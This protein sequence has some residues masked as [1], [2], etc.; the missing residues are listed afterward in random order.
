MW[1]K[2]EHCWRQLAGWLVPG[3]HVINS[4]C[5]LTDLN[6]LR[7]W[8]D[9]ALYFLIGLLSQCPYKWIRKQTKQKDVIARMFYSL[10]TRVRIL[11]KKNSMCYR[12]IGLPQIFGIS[13]LEYLSI[14]TQTGSCNYI[15]LKKKKKV[16]CWYL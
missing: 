16:L 13:L 9:F 2:D 15:Q 14:E 7:R 11:F 4:R 6:L 8:P 3:S 1:N 5:S 10:K 12:R